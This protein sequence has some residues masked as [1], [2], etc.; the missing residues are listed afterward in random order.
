MTWIFKIE[1]H[2]RGGHISTSAVD[3]KTMQS[4][5]VATGGAGLAE[6]SE[7]FNG[8]DI[9]LNT[10]VLPSA[11]VVDKRRTIFPDIWWGENRLLIISDRFREIIEDHDSSLHHIWQVT[12]LTKKGAAYPDTFHAFVPGVHAAAISEANSDVQVSEEKHYPPTA[13]LPVSISPRSA[14]LNSRWDG[15]VDLSQIPAH[16]LW[17][18]HGLTEPYLL[19]SDA[20]H[21]AIVA[22]GLKVIPMKKMKAL[23]EL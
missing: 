11:F 4:W 21:D 6:N 18:D 22:A 19:L 14:S 12:M 15:T 13:I 16:H 7:V 9:P 20:M 3:A 5:R 1:T 8:K 10:N 23:Q 2:G 17:W